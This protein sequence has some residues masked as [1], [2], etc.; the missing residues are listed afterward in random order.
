MD[1]TAL[2]SVGS[3]PGRPRYVSIESD[4]VSFA[5]LRHEFEVFGRLGYDRF[6][7]VPQHR[8]RRQQ[9]PN[10]PLEGAFVDHVFDPERA[11][12]SARRP[13]DPGSR[14]NKR[15]KRISRYF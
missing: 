5:A 6:K 10:P 7:L 2:A 9:P 12:C 8:V 4:M 3:Q 11:A 15:S 14:W 13:R 1:L